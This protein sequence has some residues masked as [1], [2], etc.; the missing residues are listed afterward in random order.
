VAT[1]PLGTAHCEGQSQGR[2]REMSGRS[3]SSGGRD[4]K[5]TGK[6]MGS[7]IL[8]LKSRVKLENDRR[9]APEVKRQTKTKG[10]RLREGFIP[11]PQKR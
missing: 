10:T 4:E 8:S 6:R 9:N 11:R 2:R 1:I 3:N 5:L 7:T